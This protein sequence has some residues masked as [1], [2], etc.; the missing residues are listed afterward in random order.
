MKQQNHK[1]YAI[2]GAGIATTALTA[3]LLW[4]NCAITVTNYTLTSSK[5]PEAFEHYRI[6]QVS[7]LHNTAFGKD[8]QTLLKKIQEAKPD[9]IVITG[10][11]I[12]SRR[13]NLEVALAFAACAVEIAPCYYVA[14]NH[15]SRIDAFP[16]LREGL[17]E[18]G[19]QILAN[20]WLSIE[21]DGQYIQIAGIFDPKFYAQEVKPEVVQKLL[22]KALP[23]DGYTILLAHRP[24]YFDVYA[25]Q[26]VDLVF[27]GHAHGG[28]MRLPVV[29]GLYAPGQG[30]LP[31]YDAGLF[32]QKDTT[33]VVSRG[34]GNSLFPLRVNNRPELVVVELRCE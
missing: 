3:A 16:E 13:T 9:S 6:V 12:D 1:K 8:N 23:P 26:G 25:E 14:G 20:E 5:L 21:K 30:V 32:Q 10:D 31:T 33:M 18:L 24:E 4:G 7:D 17:E 19:V 15:E 28:Q 22:T 27:C 2:I 29:G 11:L 34:L